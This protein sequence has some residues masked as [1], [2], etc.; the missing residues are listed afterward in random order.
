MPQITGFEAPEV[1]QGQANT[2][3]TDAFSVGK[4]LVAAIDKFTEKHES[5]Q[6]VAHGLCI[7]EWQDRLSLQGAHQQDQKNTA[8]KK[9]RS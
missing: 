2:Y 6:T 5:L 3:T 4:L 1:E 9:Q 8:S 7:P